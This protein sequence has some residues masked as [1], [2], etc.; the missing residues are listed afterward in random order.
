[1]EQWEHFKSL[2]INFFPKLLVAAAFF[3]AGWGLIHIFLRMIHKGLKHSKNI[4]PAVHSFILTISKIALQV[5][6]LLICLDAMEIPVT[7]LITAFGAVGVA[8][9][10]AVK[11]SLA[12]VLG[13]SLLL[14]SKPFV[15]G[16]YCKINGEEGY[17]TEIG[18]VYTVLNTLDNKRVFIPNG[19][20]IT[21]T[22]VNHYSEENRRLEL[23]FTIDY[24]A[25][26]ELAK[27]AILNVIKSNPLALQD[28]PPLVR[29]SGHLD[30]AIEI[31][32]RVWVPTKKYWDLNWDLWEGVKKE[33]DR[34]GINIPYPQMDVHVKED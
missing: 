30:N 28:P 7:P 17:I 29:M 25:D 6:L 32:C 10:L 5:L 16:D 2:M 27:T 18:V 21:A 26:F 12:N 22:V 4:D 33:F 9:S 20:V 14:I 15:V 1:M 31:I 8:F 3:V 11:D 24:N 19:Q 13:G 34:L 23:K